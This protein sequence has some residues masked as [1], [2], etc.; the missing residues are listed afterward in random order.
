MKGKLL[1]LGALLLSHGVAAAEEY[2]VTRSVTGK[3]EDIRDN[4]AAAIT[5]QGLVI[6]NVSH[7]GEMLERTGKDLGDNR[8]V[9]LKAEILEFCSAIVSRESMK[10]DPHAIVFC[11]YGV[12]VYV[13]PFDPDKVYLSY[14]KPQAGNTPQEKQAQ[15][16]LEKLM[17]NI[18]HEASQ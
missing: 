8:Q 5:N 14:R 7:I 3:F 15:R 10:A 2:R 16:T 4:V 1:F 9:F 13:L 6:N 18:V 17:H 11:P 12:S